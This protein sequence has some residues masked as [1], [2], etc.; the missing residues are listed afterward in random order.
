MPSISLNDRLEQLE[1]NKRA[2]NALMRAGIKRISE[3]MVM[4][5]DGLLATH[6]IGI[7]MLAEIRSKIRAWQLTH[8]SN[9]DN[10]DVLKPSVQEKSSLGATSSEITVDVL[11]LPLGLSNAIKY[12]GITTLG[13]ALF[14]VQEFHKSG[15]ISV[16]NVGHKGVVQLEQSLNVYLANHELTEQRESS[17]ATPKIGALATLMPSELYNVPIHVLKLSTRVT[18]SLLRG[19]VSNLG[20]ALQI[21]DKYND[22]GTLLIRNLGPKGLD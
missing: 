6:N 7:T 10:G 2:F 18:G 1:L 14:L 19:G 4:T 12:D 3:V 16:R 22:D 17:R 21:V 13:Q 11:D 15:T 9:P 20:E 8:P 5:D